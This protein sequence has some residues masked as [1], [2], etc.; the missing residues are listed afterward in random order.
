MTFDNSINNILNE[1]KVLE[2]K[3]SK[4]KSNIDQKDDFLVL[5]KNQ[6]DLFIDNT[7][8]FI[9][10]IL[11]FLDNNLKIKHNFLNTI[12]MIKSS[13]TKILE[14]MSIDALAQQLSKAKFVIGVDSGLTHL[15]S[16]LDIPTLGLFMHSHPNLTGIKNPHTIAENIGRYSQNPHIDEVIKKFE[17]LA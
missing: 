3:I 16:A 14:K 13:V 6:F 17:D 11:L 2:N 7:L 5:E 12:K 9:E 8:N 1:S 10:K 15:A 4:F